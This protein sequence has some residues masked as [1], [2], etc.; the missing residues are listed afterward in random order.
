MNKKIKEIDEKISELKRKNDEKIS[1]LRRKK[2]LVE[3]QQKI[4]DYDDFFSEL[5]KS[6][7]DS[8]ITAK[9][10][11]GILKFLL[12]QESRGKY[13]SNFLKSLEK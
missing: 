3:N 12:D 5:N 4:K 10:L 9:D 7:K 11:S 6:L 1:E 13:L 8:E 2:K